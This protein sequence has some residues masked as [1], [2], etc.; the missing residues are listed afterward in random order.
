MT[1]DFLMEQ[2]RPLRI[3]EGPFVS[4]SSACPALHVLFELSA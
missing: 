2:Q 4:V 3:K 1:A